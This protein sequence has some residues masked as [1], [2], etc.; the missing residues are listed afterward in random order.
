[1][2]IGKREIEVGIT[3]L[4]LIVQHVFG[5]IPINSRFVAGVTSETRLFQIKC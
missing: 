1:M 4:S 3:L 5:N 2:R